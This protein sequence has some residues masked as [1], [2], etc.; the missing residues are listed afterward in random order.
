MVLASDVDQRDGLGRS[1]IGPTARARPTRSATAT[2]APAPAPAPTSYRS[3]ST[4]G[5]SPGSSTRPL[6]TS[7]ESTRPRGERTPTRPASDEAPRCEKSPDGSAETPRPGPMPLPGTP[8][9]C[10]TRDRLPGSSALDATTFSAASE[11]RGGQGCRGK[12]PPLSTTRRPLVGPAATS[13]TSCCHRGPSTRLATGSPD[14]AGRQSA[15]PPTDPA[16]RR[17]VGISDQGGT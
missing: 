8:G 6:T 9:R 7:D 3:V 13:F 5:G 16:Q 12:H 15:D 4:P 1:C 2:P 14:E 10:T 11:R 17:R